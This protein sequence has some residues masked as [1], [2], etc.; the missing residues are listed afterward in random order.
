MND[1]GKDPSQDRCGDDKYNR[2]FLFS[3]NASPTPKTSITGPRTKG[4]SPAF[5]AFCITV[6]S[7]VIR[8]TREGVEK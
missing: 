7:V 5:T 6:T 1:K 2:Q 3:I 4:R 8:V